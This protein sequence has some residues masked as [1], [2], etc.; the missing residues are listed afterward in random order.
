MKTRSIPRLT[1]EWVAVS[2]GPGNVTVT[3]Q[4]GAGSWAINDSANAPDLQYGHS[5]PSGQDLNMTLEANEYLL[6][7]GTG[8]L[9]IVTGPELEQ[10]M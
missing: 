3:T 6:I 8:Q 7:R 10:A 9:V 4:G 5:L 1:G 2:R